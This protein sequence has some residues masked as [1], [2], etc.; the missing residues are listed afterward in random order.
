M[1]GDKQMRHTEGKIWDE[2]GRADLFTQN[3]EKS[4]FLAKGLKLNCSHLFAFD[5]IFSLHTQRV[6]GWPRIPLISVYYRLL[7][8]PPWKIRVN[9]T[10]SNQKKL[11]AIDETQ[12]RKK[13][14][15]MFHA[16][17][18]LSV[19]VDITNLIQSG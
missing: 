19:F 15:T 7:M 5:R 3:A 1:P 9:P 2:R 6:A 17:I 4:L 10:K 14:L 12:T 8:P 13:Y 18:I 11:R 16:Y